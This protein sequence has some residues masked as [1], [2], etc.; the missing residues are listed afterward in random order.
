MRVP[1]AG[2]TLHPAKVVAKGKGPHVAFPTLPL[3][4]P[5]LVQLQASN[6]N[7][8]EATYLAPKVNTPLLFRS[9]A[10]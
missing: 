8:W 10:D 2:A 9:L 6:G 5:V 3:S 4:P 7:C 1:S